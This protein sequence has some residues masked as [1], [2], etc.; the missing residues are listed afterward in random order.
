MN[1]FEYLLTEGER[2]IDILGEVW[3]LKVISSLPRHGETCWTDK[4]IYV[5]KKGDLQQD[6]D[7]LCHEILHAGR[8]IMGLEPRDPENEGYVEDEGDVKAHSVINPISFILGYVLA[9]NQG[10]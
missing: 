1:I 8:M 4:L 5:W 7:S 9:H 2:K 3:T 6:I 10:N